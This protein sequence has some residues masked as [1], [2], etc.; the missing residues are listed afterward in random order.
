MK[1]YKHFLPAVFLIPAVLF[2][3]CGANI[4]STRQEINMGKEFA[5][6]VEKQSKLLEDEEWNSYL[7]EIGQNIASICDRPDLEYNFKIVDD[8]STINAFAVPGGF[9]YIY[10][11]LLLK[12]DNEAEI[13][14]VIAHEVGHV[15]AKHSMKRLT[16]VYGFQVAMSL[17][18]GSNPNQLAK[19]GSEFLAAGLIL[20]YGRDNEFEADYYG[21]KYTHALG[22]DPNGFKTFLSKLAE[23]R[24]SGR[25]SSYLE[26]LMATHPE[27]A[28]R[29]TRVESIISTLPDNQ[30]LLRTE[31]FM[32][33][34]ARLQ[35]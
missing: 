3:E 13:A 9:V 5:V 16:Q 19:L 33:M 11:G 12:A 28:D 6:E 30:K 26:K 25:N 2:L 7:N 22:Y 34:R 31:R 8:D 21:I 4:F 32:E 24:K 18:L 1:F 14:G 17:A 35:K 20:N 15:V 27:P 10:S 23:M 29:I